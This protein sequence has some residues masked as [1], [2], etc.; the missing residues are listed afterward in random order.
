MHELAIP[1]EDL[2]VCNRYL[3]THSMTT[4][5]NELGIDASLVANILNRDHCKHYIDL[6]YRDYGFN[7]RFKM[8]EIMDELIKRKLRELD[9]NGATSNKDIIE[10]LAL[11]HKMAMDELDRQIKLES[12]KNTSI[13][14]QTNIQ[15]NDNAG[16]NYSKLLEKLLE[17][18][19]NKS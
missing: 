5:A 3:Q 18:D 15:I 2:D 11:K 10:I 16:S 19:R 8:G 4:V 14:T 17:D 6:A 12:L 7:S 1:P 13:K 9:Q